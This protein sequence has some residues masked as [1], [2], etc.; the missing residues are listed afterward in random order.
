MA[1]DNKY[2]QMPLDEIADQLYKEYGLATL[3]DR[4]IG[5][6]R[7]GCITVYRRVLYS[8]YMMGLHSKAKHVKS[9]RIVIHWA[10]SILTA[11]S[12]CMMQW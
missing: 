10:S 3:E 8:A 4:A 6:Y 12:R 7:D 9:A 2:I 5:D 11:T 1:K